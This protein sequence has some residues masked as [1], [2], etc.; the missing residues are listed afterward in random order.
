ML[1]FLTLFLLS[2]FLSSAEAKGFFLYFCFGEGCTGWD[3][4]L[5]CLSIAF[6]L[7][8]LVSACA[9]CC[10]EE[11]NEE[12]EPHDCERGS[13]EKDESYVIEMSGKAE[14]KPREKE[15]D[16]FEKPCKNCG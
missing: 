8:C 5:S 12:Q 6:T 4:T 14:C 3:T 7:F 9:S 1:H 2:F 11:E 16:A 15:K 13:V 10:K